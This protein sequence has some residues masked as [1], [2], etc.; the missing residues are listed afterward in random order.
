M[1]SYSK[2]I[3]LS[4]AFIAMIALFCLI[5]MRPE[6]YPAHSS[7]NRIVGTVL[8]LA[9]RPVS[10]IPFMLYEGGNPDCIYARISNTSGMFQMPIPA[11]NVYYFV[12][13]VDK[14]RILLQSF[15]VMLQSNVV[16]MT[17]IYSGINL[18]QTAVRPSPPPT[19]PEKPEVPPKQI[20][21]ASCRERV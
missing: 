20:G 15:N 10:G 9:N 19:L 17:F 5:L 14:E 13:I 7:K 4:C 11:P 21:R 3:V 18:S 12:T 1:K 6:G 16:D 8:D 2:T